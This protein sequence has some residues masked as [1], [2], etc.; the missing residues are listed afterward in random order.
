MKALAKALVVD[1]DGTMRAILRRVFADAGVLVD[2]FASARE[3]L[4]R[5]DLLTPAV[6]LLDVQM[7]DMSGLELQT[8]LSE[9]GVTL[10]VMFL[11]GTSDLPLA[12]AAM[13][14]GAVDFLEKP[15]DPVELVSRVRRAFAMRV[16]V[17]VAPAREPTLESPGEFERRLSTLSPREREVYDLMIT[18]KTSKLIASELGGS[19]R[20][21]EIHRS[22]VMTKM[23]APHLADLVRMA[24]AIEASEQRQRDGRS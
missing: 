17:A 10:P 16:P 23:Q 18:G 14:S 21:I 5:G 24:F 13:R 15:F 7:P 12:V 3:L 1:D 9:R 2:D 19:F 6:L 20:T 4:E 22:R 11:S 8:L